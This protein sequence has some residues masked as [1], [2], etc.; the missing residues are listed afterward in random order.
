MAHVKLFALHGKNL[1][2]NQA[3]RSA[4]SKGFLYPVC[5]IVD[6]F[7]GI[8]HV[9]KDTMQRIS[10]Y[11]ADLIV[12]ATP[13]KKVKFMVS[14]PDDQKKEK[15]NGKKTEEN[16]GDEAPKDEEYLGKSDVDEKK[17]IDADGKGG[18]DTEEMS[19][20]EGK[21][22]TN[23]GDKKETDSEN[24]DMKTPDQ[25]RDDEPPPPTSSQLLD[26]L[27]RKEE[28]EHIAQA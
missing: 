7:V 4:F 26:S 27:I 6:A 24:E 5:N 8:F 23:R 28:R 2:F 22:E 17:E 25:E 3:F 15:K 19:D 20:A 12:I 9:H 18:A 13:M 1:T 21:I 10:Q 14:E 16:E 11:N